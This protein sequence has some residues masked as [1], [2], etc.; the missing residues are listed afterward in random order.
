MI[1]IKYSC[2]E[3]MNFDIIGLLIFGFFGYSCKL[4]THINEIHL[5]FRLLF[6]YF[7]STSALNIYTYMLL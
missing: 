5:S 3:L 1:I 6:N 4:L 7:C 2:T